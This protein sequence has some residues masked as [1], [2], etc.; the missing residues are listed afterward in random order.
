LA[1]W[2][3]LFGRIDLE[4]GELIDAGDQIVAVI[5]EREIGRSSGAPVETTQVALWT[6]ADRKATR[7][8]MFDDRQQALEAAGLRD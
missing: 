3:G 5:R 2:T 1:G 6:L 8:R 4:V 7:M